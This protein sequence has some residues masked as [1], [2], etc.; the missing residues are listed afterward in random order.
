MKVK[1]VSKLS[2][3][4]EVI[5]LILSKKSAIKNIGLKDNHVKEITKSIEN[6]GYSFKSNEII[7][8]I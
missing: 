1:F 7:E 8:I 6:K 4:S 2:K 3:K 5:F